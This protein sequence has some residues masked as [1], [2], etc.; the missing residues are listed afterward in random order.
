MF[1]EGPDARPVAYS[2]ALA[3]RD[4]ALILP[5][6]V[7]RHRVLAPGEAA[8]PLGPDGGGRADGNPPAGAGP[9]PRAP[10]SNCQIAWTINLLSVEAVRNDSR[11]LKH[12]SSRE[13][14][15]LHEEIIR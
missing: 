10:H 14:R 4:F 6:A 2:W 15:L 13:N 8:R 7:R 5:S 9:E 1:K 11:A 12:E 3:I